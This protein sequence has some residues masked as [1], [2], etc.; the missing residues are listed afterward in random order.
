MLQEEEKKKKKK[1]RANIRNRKNVDVEDHS[2]SKK[3]EQ[4]RNFSISSSS[5]FFC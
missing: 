5:S 3:G 4:M 1:E 2:S